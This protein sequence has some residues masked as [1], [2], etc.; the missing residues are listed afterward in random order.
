MQVHSSFFDPPQVVLERVIYQMEKVIIGKRDCIEKLL[1]ALL[2]GGHVLLEDVP[3]VGKTMLVRA[4]S[5]TID[6]SFKRIQCT[7]DL[8]P[9]DLTGSSVYNR[10]TSL[11]EFRPGPLMANMVL[12]DELNR[13]TPRT[14]SAMLEA[15]EERRITVDGETYPL[16]EPFFVLATQNPFDFEGTFVLPEAQLDRFL[17]K[18]SLGY[19]DAA[20]E[21]ELL[22]RVENRRPV[23]Q[24]RPLL[25]TEEFVALQKEASRVHVDDS[26]KSYIVQLAAA[27]R[28]HPDIALGASPRATIALMR[29]AQGR[30][31]L[32][33]RSYVIP[34]DVKRLAVPVLA[35]RLLL[36]PEAAM[37]QKQ[38]AAVMD[39]IAAVAPIPPRAYAPAQ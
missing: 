38:A 4:L 1:I 16:P 23:D 17:M 27:T 37:E 7:P 15:M 35:H 12:A 22:D 30:A 3:G 33:G 19:P 34:D 11:F 21:K 14:Q 18:L 20:Q 29:A 39:S 28:S 9:S 31:F 6:G 25:L 13:A 2:C 36:S 26:V 10:Q 32:S 5:R 24:L 8:L